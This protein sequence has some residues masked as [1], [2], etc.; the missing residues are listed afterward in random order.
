MAVIT[1]S[2][3]IKDVQIVEQGYV[4]NHKVLEG[5]WIDTG[6]KDP[7]LECNRLVLEVL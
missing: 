3:V 4:V 5:W 7:L 6:K 1:E 2:T